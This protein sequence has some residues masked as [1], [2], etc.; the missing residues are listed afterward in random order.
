[1]HAPKRKS[2][3]ALRLDAHD[4]AIGWIIPA[5]LRW[6]VSMWLRALRAMATAA[7]RALHSGG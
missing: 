5:Q 4:V 1:V 7:M 2:C 6:D 3:A